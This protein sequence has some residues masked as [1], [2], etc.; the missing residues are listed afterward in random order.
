MP[1]NDII[2][3]SLSSGLLVFF[4]SSIVIYLSLFET[5]LF[6]VLL[7]NKQLIVLHEMLNTNFI[8]DEIET[9]VLPLSS[10]VLNDFPE[11]LDIGFQDP[12]TGL[13]ES[14]ILLHH[15]I[16]FFELIVLVTVLYFFYF[17]IYSYVSVLPINRSKSDSN[18][19]LRVS[20]LL[21]ITHAPELE[22]IWTSLPAILLTII[23]IPSILLLF[24]SDRLHASSLI[25]KVLGNQWYWH[26]NVMGENSNIMGETGSS[27]ND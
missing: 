23:A 3:Y 24:R 18:I 22:I 15:D 20:P 25:I 17:I 26:Y 16:M 6:N 11:K 4:L 2:T 7:L 27:Y 10:S 9:K 8:Y 14:L 12:A 1:Q 19:T 13:L 21:N 5:S